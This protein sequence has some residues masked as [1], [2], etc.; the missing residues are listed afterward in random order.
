MSM[1]KMRRLL[2]VAMLV[3][4]GMVAS[5][6]ASVLVSNDFNFAGALTANGWTAYSGADGSVTSDLSVAWVGG[7]AEDINTGFTDQTVNPTYAS[8][9]LKVASLP[10]SGGDYCFGFTDGTTME[11]RFGIAVT[12]GGTTFR[13]AAYGSGST[14]VATSGTDLSLAT[15]YTVVM[16]FDGV[17]DHRLWINPSSGSFATPDAQATAANSGMDGFF[18][19]QAGVLDAGASSWSIDNV[20]VATTFG[21]LVSGAPVVTTNVK[22]SAS[23]ASVAENV[24]TYV[25]TVTKSVAEGDVS[26]EITLGGTATEGVSND[27]TIDTTN[28]VMNGATTSAT[29]TVTIN[30]DADAEVAETIVLG[31]ANVAGGD[32]TAPSTFTLTIQASDVSSSLIL[33]QYTETDSGSV[34]K[35]IELWNVSGGDIT[36]DSGANLLTIEVA[37]GGASTTTNSVSSGTVLNGQ[38]LV[39]G[40]SDMSP[41]VTNAYTFNGDDAITVK[42]GGIVQDVF[43]QPGIDP[44][45]AWTSNGVSTANQNI[46]LKAG[47]TTGDLDGWADPSE[48]FENVGI[49]SV[50]TGFGVPP[51]GA[52]PTNV[53]FTAASASVGEASGTYVV[54]VFKS[55]ADGNVSGEVV[56][57]GTATA[58]V[59]DDYTI[60]TTNFVMNGATTSATFTVTINNDVATEVSETITLTLANVVGGTIV[61]PSVFTLTIADN[62]AEPE[63]IAAFRFTAAPFLDVTT[64]DANITVSNLSLSVGT[65]DTDITTGTYFP[66]EPYVEE[67][68]GWTA[69]DQAS[70]KHFKFT[71]VPNS[72]YQVSITGISFRAYA[73]GSGPSAMGYDINAGGASFAA[74][75][76]NDILVVVSNAVTGVDDV[77]API[78]I[79]IQGWTNGTRATTGGG[80]FRIDDIVVFGLVETVGG[81]GDTTLDEYDVDA[82][83]LSGS[84]FSITISASSNGVPYTLIYTTNILT[85]PQG[86]GTADVE[87]GNGG[88][89]ILQ[90]VGPTDSSRLYW[91]RS[92]N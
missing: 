79:L 31:L 66:N 18:I 92:N 44:G 27:Y 65:I 46:Q 47:I 7:G 38:V 14:P 8:F 76:T 24:G 77:T 59:A 34:P 82:M 21:D 56:L 54:T 26:G 22:F 69:A 61:A 57:G 88:T 35:G 39:I 67:S 36:F 72:G 1:T 16:Y 15:D 74:D 58:G 83:S 41:N 29:F 62:D 6:Q 84:T 68:G 11:S 49:G 32:I 71:I 20:T 51:G 42:L 52:A 75:L 86:S 17:N 50:L 78:D 5:S 45:S 30:D 37:F 3:A 2:S 13:L 10:S 89:L 80:A 64:K 19:R 40:T 4:I 53:A 33:S 90:D 23:A 60:D 55:L 12:G 25:V 48:R 85:N 63:G 81:G 70:A 91:I 9:I 73:T 87:N 28:F 43:G